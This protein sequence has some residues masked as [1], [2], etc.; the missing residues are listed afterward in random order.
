[1]SRDHRKLEVFRE[2]DRLVIDIYRA[3]AGLPIEE[4]FGLQSQLRRAAVSVACNIVEGAA[5][6]TE[7]EYCRFLSIAH[8]SARESE[9]LLSVCARLGFVPELAANAL[10]DR[11]SGVSAGLARLMDAIERAQ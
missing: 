10:G 4:R 9:Y 1:M 5:R 3:T 6:K 11:F 7:P 2:A 8:A